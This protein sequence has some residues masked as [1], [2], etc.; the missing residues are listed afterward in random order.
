[1]DVTIGRKRG[2]PWKYID[3]NTAKE[4]HYVTDYKRYKL[5]YPL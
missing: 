2:R 3:T 4:G 5:F 1:M